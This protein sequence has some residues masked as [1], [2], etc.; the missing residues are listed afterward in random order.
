LAF[1]KSTNLAA[2]YG[3]AVTGTMG[4]TSVLFYAVARTLWKWSVLR[5]GALTLLFLAVDL[6][7]FTANATKIMQGGWVPLAVGLVVFTTMT[8]WKRG[9]DA[10]YQFLR[11]ITLP[12]DMFM[13]DMARQ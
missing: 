10:L 5:A 4:I 9:R 12:L 11:G 13:E 7:F 2:A 8:T 6:S 3:I 1:Q